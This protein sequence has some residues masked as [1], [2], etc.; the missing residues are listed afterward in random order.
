MKL[1]RIALEAFRKFRQPVALEDLDGGLNIIV[2]PNEAGKST[3]VAALRAA[4]LER[5]A[6]NKPLADLAPWDMPDARPSVTVDFTHDGHAYSLR[7][8]FLHRALRV[9][10]R[11]RRATP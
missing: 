10:D 11:R 7:K 3:F 9:A 1:R 6:T 4:F 5:Y 2:G 8:Q